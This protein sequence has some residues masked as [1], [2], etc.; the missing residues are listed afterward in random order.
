MLHRHAVG[1][2][3]LESDHYIDGFGVKTLYACVPFD[4]PDAL[5][6]SR[7][8]HPIPD[9]GFHAEG[10]EYVALLDAIERFASDGSLSRWRRVPAG[11]H[12]WRWRVWSAA[13]VG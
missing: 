3:S 12:G 4:S 13:A 2:A 10:I 9:D 5:N 6:L 8:E 1:P 11:A 7:L